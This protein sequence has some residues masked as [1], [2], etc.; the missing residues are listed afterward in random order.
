MSKI[1][2]KT[3]AFSV[4]IFSGCSIAA[5]TQYSLPE[6]Q[7]S[8]DLIQKQRQQEKIYNEK[9]REKN[10]QQEALSTVSELSDK[11][12]KSKYHFMIKEIVVEGDDKYEFSPERN[13]I[14]SGFLN[15][16][17]GEKEVMRL[18]GELTNFYISRGYVT[19]QITIVPGSLRSEKLV[20][21]VL[22]GKLSGFL[23]NGNAPGWREKTR[24]FSAM[25]FT[26]G[27]VLTMSD[28][29]QGLDNLLRVSSNDKLE[30]VPSEK[31]G[32]SLID[33]KGEGVFPVSL[34]TGLNNS[35]YKD[36]GWYQYY[37]S[38]SIKN[39]I[40][41][42][43]NINYFYSYNDLDSKPDNQYAK[44]VSLS[45]PLGYWSFDTSYYKSKYKKIVG[46]LWGGYQ[47][48]GQSERTSLKVSRTLYRNSVGK[49]SGYVKLEKREN[50]NFIMESPVTISSKDYSSL[51]AGMN[52]V[53]SAAGGWAYLDFNMTKGVP[54]FSTAWNSD[55]DLD[56]FDLDYKKYNGMLN[57]SKRL[58]ASDN[59]I[60]TLDYELNSGFQFTNDVLVSDAKMSVGDEYSVRGFKESSVSTERAAWISNTFKMPVNIN[61]AR[62]YQL[63]P[64]TGFDIGLARRNCPPE[65]SSCDRDYL[66]GAVLG[67]K[68]NGKDFSGSFTAGWPI[69]R[70]ASLK[71]TPLDN[72]V[73]YFNLDV[74]F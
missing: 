51:T 1:F 5:E 68:A 10:I 26:R 74:G 43:D 11:E 9:L 59:G 32:H 23:D 19:T 28:I 54:W 66:S 22:W 62:I 29:D 63:S 64:F 70:P 13:A 20:L 65:V 36:S 57:W 45:L 38:A 6:S 17:M 52:W 41:L 47:S 21:K 24:M 27:K 61:Y 16:K 40:G 3:L 48:D 49:L 73:Y 18:V 35:G 69:K 37:V 42:N 53:G 58:A 56:G 71:N 44:S 7:R 33:H 14:I 55:R 30:I 50:E 8:L 2:I 60:V 31:D 72:Q 15:L 4:V 46:G 67:V 39:I 25:P 34:H 12:G